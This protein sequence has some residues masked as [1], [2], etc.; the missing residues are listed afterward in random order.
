MILTVRDNGP[1]IPAEV[2]Q[3][4]FERGFTTKKGRGLGLG[5]SL[6][7]SVVEAHGGRIRHLREVSPG[8]E[9]WL[10]LPAA[11]PPDNSQEVWTR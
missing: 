1:G 5:L 11:L 9:F 8:A 10:E 2:Q 6:V 7:Q 4:L 3:R